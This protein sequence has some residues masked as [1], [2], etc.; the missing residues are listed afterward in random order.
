MPTLMRPAPVRRECPARPLRIC[1][2]IDELA[3]AGTETQLL[4]LIRRLNRRRFA[5][6]LCLLRGESAASRSQEPDCCPVHRLCVGSLAR[7]ATLMKLWRFAAWLKAEGIDV[8]QTYFPDSSYFGI[9][10]AWLA[11]VP[12]RIRTRNNLGHWLTPMH[13]RLGHWFNRL[14][15]ATIANCAAARDAL[16]AAEGPAPESVVVLENGVDLD[17]FFAVPP[18]SERSPDAPLIGAVANLR[19]VKGLDVLVRAMAQVRRT[20]PAAVCRIAGEGESRGDLRR[21][22]DELDVATALELPGSF[23]DIPGFLSR[24]DVAVLSSRAEGMSNALLEYMAAGRPIVATCV[25]ANPELIADG[26]HGLLVPP[27]DDAALA[28]AIRRLLVDREYARRL[29][30]AARERATRDFG[31]AAMVERF[32]D[33]YERLRQPFA[34]NALQTYR[35]QSS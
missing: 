21:L 13:R 35:E 34:R 22:A 7:P 8:V 28:A 6:S 2:L 16:I 30:S 29:G 9:T 32:E 17:R 4:A 11:G 19:P 1:F 20:H 33:F 23:A 26:M 31:R 15:T 24:L 14:T 3:A 5:P 18:L 25:G 27:D 12:H 10:A